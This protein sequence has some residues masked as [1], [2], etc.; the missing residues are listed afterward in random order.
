LPPPLGSLARS[1]AKHTP[2]QKLIH[3][4]FLFLSPANTNPPQNKTH[5]KTKPT[6]KQNQQQ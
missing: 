1:L 6:T 3:P 4:L 2:K 5:H